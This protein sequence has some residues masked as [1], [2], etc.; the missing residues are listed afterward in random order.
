MSNAAKGHL[1]TKFP[2]SK[3]Y[4]Y[5]NLDKNVLANG[6]YDESAILMMPMVLK[7]PTVPTNHSLPQWE[8]QAPTNT[9]TKK[10]VGSPK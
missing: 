7:S 4:S 10:R 5:N 8:A 3:F 1:R 9:V 2:S 6:T